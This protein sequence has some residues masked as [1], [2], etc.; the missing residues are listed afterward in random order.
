MRALR[1]A[2]ANRAQ[3][4]GSDEESGSDNE[5]GS[6]DGSGSDVGSGGG[7]G[8]DSDAESAVS[9]THSPRPSPPRPVA[10]A[11]VATTSRV[12]LPP[13]ADAKGKASTVFDTPRVAANATF[14]SL[15]LSQ[16]AIQALATL[17]IKAPTEIQTA[18]IPAMLA[19]R[20]V[21]GGAKTGS[22]KTLAFAL[23]ILERLARDPFGIAALV[24]TPT[25]ELAYQ[26][27]EQ[28]LA[29]GKPMGLTTE[30]IVGGMD[31]LAQAQ[32]LERRPHIVV[33]TP[34]RLCDLLR[35]DGVEQ[36]K[37]RRVRTLVL[38]EADRM[39]TPT[40]APELAY[41]FEQIPK[42][43]QTCLFTAT[44]SDAIMDLA[45]RPPPPGK[46]AP[47]VYRVASD[48][49]TVEKLKQ[50]YLFIPSQI[51]DPYLYYLLLNPPSDI[52]AVLAAPRPKPK[53]KPTK[54]GKRAR[55]ATPEDDT[56]HIVPTI[57]F[58]QRCATAQLLHLI[59][60]ELDIPSVPL[61][62]HLTQPQRLLSLARFRAREVPVLVTTDVGS[63][64][65][66]IPEVAMVVNWDCPRRAD[67]YVHRVGRTARA[68]R[69]GV[70][71][72]I[73]TERDVELVQ[74]IEKEIKV[75]LAELELPESTVLEN[76]NRVSAARR[77]AAMEMSDSKFGERKAINQAKAIKR[78]RRD[79]AK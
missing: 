21:I 56:P 58:T 64:G 52:D 45:K 66:D 7:D 34:G 20:D 35:S 24:L 70:A 40:F 30:T 41:L 10:R 19:G 46:Q 27:A 78:A 67:D 59:L 31:M 76:L 54:R 12:K 4:S 60:E 69:G 32:A 68:G 49:M 22:G 79:A 71:V 50:K 26:L 48:T 2:A 5:S 38:D 55:S 62:S 1:E 65:L 72:T 61:H 42:S 6:D 11:S 39:L 9:S 14:E 29:V 18:T 16:P 43:R 37:L 23:P 77:M 51:R 75:T 73:V 36:G 13:K 44:I 17:S 28:F 3:D 47:F 33:A 63:R 25:R 8:S 57:I 74:S 15:G 53:P